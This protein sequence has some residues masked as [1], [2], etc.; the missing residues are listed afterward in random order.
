M[1][2]RGTLLALFIAGGSFTQQKTL[3]GDIIAV[4]HSLMHGPGTSGSCVVVGF[5]VD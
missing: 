1:D 4:W 3:W 5:D 2:Y